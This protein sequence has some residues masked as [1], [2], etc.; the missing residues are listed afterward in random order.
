MKFVHLAL[1]GLVSGIKINSVDPAKE[2]TYDVVI[3]P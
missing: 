2:Q 3:Q 1:L